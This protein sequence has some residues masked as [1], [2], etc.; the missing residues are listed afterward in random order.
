MLTFTALAMLF[1]AP[2]TCLPHEPRPRHDA[3]DLSVQ[4]IGR[5]PLDSAAAVERCLL[6]LNDALKRRPAPELERL[7][8]E[9]VR[10]L[11][12]A[13]TT[14]AEREMLDWSEVAALAR[15]GVEIGSQTVHHAILSRVDAAMARDEVVGSVEQIAAHT[16]TAARHFAYPNGS[17]ADFGERDVRLV[18]EAGFATATTTVE[19]V[20]RPGA[21]P[22]RLLRHN[23]HECRFLSPFG[24]LSRALFCSETSG[25]L[26]WL[27]SWRNR[28]CCRS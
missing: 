15:A 13:P 14:D 17:G 22:Y 3:L 18:R 26:D 21:D 6:E 4:G 2:L 16:G 9:I 10:Q 1:T 28:R 19:G 27:R 12:P 7:V 8:D 24:T 5:W 11:D 20:N 23:I 25:V